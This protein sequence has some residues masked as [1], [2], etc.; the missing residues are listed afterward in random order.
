MMWIAL[1]ALTFIFFLLQMGFAYRFYQW[2]KAPQQ[3]DSNTLP[4]LSIVVLARNEGANLQKNLRKLLAQDYP[5]YELVWVDDDSSDQS[6]AILAQLAQE[7]P[8]LQPLYY[9]GK[10][11]LGKKEALLWAIP[12]TKYNWILLTDA[13]GQPASPLWAKKMMQA[14][15]KNS[16][17]LVLGFGPYLSEKTWLNSWIRYETALVALQYFSAAHYNQAYMGVG[18]N[19]LYHKKVFEAA[20][21]AL[22]AS[23]NT[24]S[25]DDDIL[26]STAQK[27]PINNCL[28]PQA[29]V[30]SAPKKTWKS[31]FRQKRRHYSSSKFYQNTTKWMLA[32]WSASFLGLPFFALSLCFSPFPYLALLWPIRILFFYRVWQKTLLTLEQDDLWGQLLWAELFAL[33][34][35]PFM[36]LQFLRKKP[37]YWK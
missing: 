15:P 33:L 12:Q 25:G 35:Y 34:Y 11:Y 26:V 4:P 13:D 32:L 6:P 1:F 18:R 19:L 30:Y 37:S 17:G 9:R 2:T 29:F 20:A 14:R 7:N 31:L 23:I 22:A 36:A 28:D 5:I 27:F 3:T 24:P 21:P 10:K 16:P 8:K